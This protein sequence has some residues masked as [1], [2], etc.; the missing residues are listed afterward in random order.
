[1]WAD[2]ISIDQRNVNEW[3]HQVVLMA[4]MFSRAQKVQAY[5]TKQA[6]FAEQ[7]SQHEE[8]DDADDKQL[9]NFLVQIFSES[10]WSRLWIV[11]EIY[12]ARRMRFWLGRSQLN[13]SQ[14]LEI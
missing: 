10:Y 13:K 2:Q 3:G 8:H 11:Q 9:V 4:Q 1:M 7:A 5:L 12:L 14:L 6:T